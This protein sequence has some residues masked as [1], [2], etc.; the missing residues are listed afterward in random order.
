[1]PAFD[2]A[3]DPVVFDE[4]VFE[5]QVPIVSDSSRIDAALVALLL[6]DVGSPNSLATMLPDGVFFDEANPGATRFVLV[7]LLEHHDEPTFEGRAIEDALYLVK[8]VAKSD[9]GVNMAAAAARI[10]QLLEDRRLTEGSPLGEVDGFTWMTVHRESRIRL[11][12]VDDLNPAIRWDHRG[13]QYRVQ[14]AV[15]VPTP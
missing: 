6:A 15:V 12:E 11:R 4:T 13:G 1:M 7:S 5:E 8:A 3:F 10:D 9:A 14:M 2:A